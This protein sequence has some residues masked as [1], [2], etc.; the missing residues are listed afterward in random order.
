MIEALERLVDAM[1]HELQHYGEM[2]RLLD[3][4]HQFIM[5]RAMEDVFQSI[6]AIQT[7][8]A[9]IQDARAHREQCQRDIARLVLQPDNAGFPILIL[10]VLPDYRPLIRAL[11]DENNELLFRV[12]QRAGEN[13]L[14]L[15]HTVKVMQDLLNTLASSHETRVDN[16]NG[17]PHTH[18]HQP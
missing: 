8:G 5:V 6:A 17:T 3:Y 11:A 4:Q 9:T 10:L 13:H 18:T 15:S 1:R 2:L 7:Q 14:L 16:G 12:R